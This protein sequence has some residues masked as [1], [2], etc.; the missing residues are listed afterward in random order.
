MQKSPASA[1]LHTAERAAG[2]YIWVRAGCGV[3][4]AQDKIKMAKDNKKT[5][6]RSRKREGCTVVYRHLRQSGTGRVFQRQGASSSC[7]LIQAIWELIQKD[8]DAA[9]GHRPRER[10]DARTILEPAAEGRQAGQ[11]ASRRRWRG[12]RWAAPDKLEKAFGGPP[13]P[14]RLH[15]LRSLVHVPLKPP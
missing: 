11:L 3:G 1:P 13:P 4:A 15:L 2:L 5:C 12:S 6:R 8:M 7:A 9:S 14:A 10:G